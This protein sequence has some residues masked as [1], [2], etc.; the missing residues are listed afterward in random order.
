MFFVVLAPESDPARK[1]Q[2]RESAESAA[3]YEKRLVRGALRRIAIFDVGRVETFHRETLDSHVIRQDPLSFD[4]V[5]SFLPRFQY[6]HNRIEIRCSRRGARWP[7]ADRPA[8]RLRA[9]PRDIFKRTRLVLLAHHAGLR[10]V[11]RTRAHASF[12]DSQR[13]N[14][15]RSSTSGIRLPSRSRDRSDCSKH[16]SVSKEI[17][18]Y[19]KFSPCRFNA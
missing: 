15:A 9:W 1:I 13:N 12:P 2:G 4:P 5:F 18:F 11:T 3:R 17:S 19:R 8:T 16:P 7:R 14:G 10:I 6:G